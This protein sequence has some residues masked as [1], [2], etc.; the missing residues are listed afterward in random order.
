LWIFLRG[1]NPSTPWHSLP[2]AIK[3]ITEMGASNKRVCVCTDDRDAHDIFHFGLDWV[4]RQAT[5]AGINKISSWS[6]G[7]LH[8]AHRYNIDQNYGAL[9]GGRRADIVL[10]NQDYEV[11]NTWFGGELLVEDKKI[12]NLLEQ[13]LENKRY[14]YPSKAYQTIK[15]SKK[16]NLIPL[17][18][19][20]LDIINV[21]KTELPGIVTK[22]I[23][24]KI[25]KPID[26]WLEI[27]KEHNLTHLAVIERYGKTNEIAYG[28]IKDFNLK[29][30]AV[31][32]SVGHDA[33][34]VIIAGTNEE[35][36]QI[37]L[38]EIKNSQGCIVI[39]DNKKIISKIDLP[40][41]GLL[42]DKR[43]IEVAKETKEFKKYWNE[44]KCT[45][46]Y[47]GF[48]LLPLSVIP[49]FRLTN[50]GLVDV[51]SMKIIPL[52]E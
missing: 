25:N 12:T 36:M 41:A 16:H 13:Q 8:P 22:H 35:D 33:H 17:I 49:E 9:G 30:G 5:K 37:V 42:S 29:S 2:E 20:F 19:E 44:Y 18:P 31:G 3:A 46:P 32:S 23:Q 27:T 1:G 14:Q 10:L 45:I 38:E 21:I 24:I 40:I 4:V 34:N 47:M 50:K 28:F 11:Q 48:N 7:S 26:N 43:A 6:M 15:I 39:V 52:F 51:N